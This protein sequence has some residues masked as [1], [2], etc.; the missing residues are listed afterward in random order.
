MNCSV[1]AFFALGAVVLAVACSSTSDGDGPG[2]GAAGAPASAGATNAT[3][4]SA[5]AAG[6]STA[7]GPA[8]AGSPAVAGA[9]AVAGSGGSQVAGSSNGGSSN[10]GA[11]SAGAGG[12]SNK[13][14]KPSAGC[15]KA[16]TQVTI[17]NSLV[18]IPTGYTGKDPVPVVIAFHAAGNDNTSMQNTFKS[19]DLAK[20]YLIVYPNSTSATTTNKTGWSIQA[21]KTR[22][23]EV[24]AAI[25]SQA[26][27]DEN[28]IY[29]TGH[30][31]GAQFVVSLL[32]DGVADFD[33]VAPVAS[34][35]YCQKWKNGPVPALIIHGVK[36]EERTKYN[37]NDGDGKKDLQPYLTSNMCQMTSTPFQPDVSKCSN[38]QGIDGKPFSAGCVEF[39]GCSVKTRWCNHNDPNY[40][41]TNHGIP[42]F[43]VRAIYDFFESL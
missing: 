15:A 34:S 2:A 12:G 9:P 29:A 30:S 21:D 13:P 40:G 6:G 11:T 26:C 24:Q 1:S 20:K 22:Y 33:A 23:T 4:G 42:C 14:V 28:R 43:G 41:T 18:G 35:V 5:P 39:S 3:A 31:S 17:P 16:S 27:V 25:L 36:D 7:G 19:S 10:G 32:C 37:L 38:I 8:V